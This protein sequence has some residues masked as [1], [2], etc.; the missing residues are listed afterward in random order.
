MGYEGIP[1][2]RIKGNKYLIGTKVQYLQQ[3][4]NLVIIQDQHDSN[5][6]TPLSQFLADSVV[7]EVK[8]LENLMQYHDKSL[9]QTV[10]LL[11]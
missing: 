5:N 3:H 1:V 10:E 8:Q 11:V 4:G 7:K 9:V 2:I 6:Q